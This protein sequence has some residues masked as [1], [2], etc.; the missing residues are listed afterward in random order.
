MD[1]D[2]TVRLRQTLALAGLAVALV[3]CGYAVA[4]GDAKVIFGVIAAIALIAVALTHR[5]AFIGL[6]V[7]MAMDGVP[8]IDTS[9]KLFSHVTG[10][11]VALAALIVVAALWAF[12]D[13]GEA[14]AKRVN[15][16]LSW[17]GVALL[18]WWVYTV[19]RTSGDGGASTLAAANFGRD[20]GGFAV[21]LIFVPRIHL[22]SHE[23]MLLLATLA[24]AVCIY[25]VGQIIT[26]LGLGNAQFIVHAS[27]TST[28]SLGVTRVYAPMNDLL[29]A[30]L[31]GAI[32][33]L[34]IARSP[35]LRRIATP[36]AIL[37]LISFGV[38]FTRARWIGLIVAL[39]VV[40]LRFVLGRDPGV[41]PLLRKRLG[42]F[43][44]GVVAVGGIAILTAPQYIFSG[45]LIQRV[46]SIFTAV[47]SSTSTVAVR[48]QVIDTL[49][50]MLAGHWWTGLGLIPPTAHYY[51]ALPAGSLRD[52]DVGLF[53]GV[54]T[55]GIIGTAL[56]F[57][58]VIVVLVH[59]LR[60][61][62]PGT[63]ATDNQWL[64]YGIA[65]W[66]VATL[67]SSLTITTLFN[68]GGLVMTAAILMIT[69]HPTV[70]GAEERIR[71]RASATDVL[72]V[73]QLGEQEHPQLL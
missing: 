33:A 69:I 50:N 19:L 44:A 41:T 27:H 73:P 25:A 10:E 49:S 67:V 4:H 28:G 51:T 47:Q 56:I 14:P 29:L 34:A 63:A 6:L 62:S 31:S 59:T 58:P 9:Q 36:I 65:I 70:T 39:L 22:D 53:G 11:D 16:V 54:A 68:L 57:L 3:C 20:F 43:V 38:E 55:I 32:G 72:A 35:R 2:L 18:A 52:P 17:C 60:R 30:G 13:R 1:L 24:V 64:R 21:L 40:T 42:W 15:Q 46:T 45:S 8:G 7:I 23:V 37:L 48:I 5:G 66:L 26:A 71:R 61:S 12:A